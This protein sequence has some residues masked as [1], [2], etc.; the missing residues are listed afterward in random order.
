MTALPFDTHKLMEIRRQNDVT[1]IG[2]FGSGT[3]VG[4][5]VRNF[6]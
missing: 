6:A 4:F 2:V 5:D 1:K 3:G